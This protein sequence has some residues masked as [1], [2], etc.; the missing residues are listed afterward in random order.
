MHFDWRKFLLTLC[1]S[2]ESSPFQFCSPLGSTASLSHMPFHPPR[3]LLPRLCPPSPSQALQST[4]LWIYPS[5]CTKE[6]YLLSTIKIRASVLIS[7]SSK[8]LKSVKITLS[9][10][11]KR[12][13]PIIKDKHV[14]KY[15][16][17]SRMK[18][19]A[20]STPNPASSRVL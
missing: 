3:A 6:A 17:G 9:L 13:T 1:N 19:L 10:D 7:P 11:Y 16:A 20:H 12:F 18:L 2:F 4:S 15:L 5:A 8:I 14:F